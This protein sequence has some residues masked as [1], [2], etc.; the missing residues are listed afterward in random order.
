MP[1]SFRMLIG[2]K[3]PALFNS[4]WSEREPCTEMVISEQRILVVKWANRDRNNKEYMVMHTI[5]AFDGTKIFDNLPVIFRA[6][7][8]CSFELMRDLQRHLKKQ[9]LSTWDIKAALQVSNSSIPPLFL[10]KASSN[11]VETHLILIERK[12]PCECH[13]LWKPRH[14]LKVVENPARMNGERGPGRVGEN[15]VWVSDEY[16]AGCLPG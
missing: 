14:E 1:F 7:Q 3:P 9:N 12:K 2:L 16:R 6:P 8:S 10:H 11:N 15:G 4:L 13:K 5:Y